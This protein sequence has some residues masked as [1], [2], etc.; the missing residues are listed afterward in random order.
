MKKILYIVSAMLPV[1][2]SVSCNKIPQSERNDLFVPADSNPAENSPVVEGAWKIDTVVTGAVYKKFAGV[3]HEVTEKNQIVNVME[4]DLTNPRLHVKFHYGNIDGLR[5]TDKVFGVKRDEEGAICCVNATYETGSVYI[6]TD[7]TNYMTIADEKINGTNVRQWKSEACVTSDGDSDV[8]IEYTAP[9]EENDYIAQR[10]AYDL[11]TDR[12]NLFSSAPMLVSGGNPVGE[13]FI[14]RMIASKLYGGSEGMDRKQIEKLAYENPI[15]HQGVEHPRTVVALT[16]DKKLLLITI[17]GRWNAAVGM[18]AKEITQFI[19]HHFPTI[20][21]A[22][23]MDGGGSTC[24]CVLGRG[25]ATNYVVNYPSEDNVFD[26]QGIRGV[27]THFYVTWD[28][29]AKDE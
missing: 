2:A 15:R 13:T 17:D 6:R 21:D 23:N 25:D 24:M 1:L 5:A 27:P 9:A 3:D 7:Y 22:L 10:H 12:P 29:P 14:E 18:S 28:D 16:S 20:T 11:M 4:I 19:M 8:R 26:H